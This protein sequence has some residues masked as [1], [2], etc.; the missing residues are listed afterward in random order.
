MRLYAGTTL[1]YLGPIAW[2]LGSHASQ[3]VYQRDD[4]APPQPEPIVVTELPLPP[5][6][7][8]APGSC[9]PEINSNR[10][11]CLDRTSKLESGS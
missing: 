10:S 2:V 9:T 6:A 11:G 1:A 3:V 7:N 8:A 5:V 4:V